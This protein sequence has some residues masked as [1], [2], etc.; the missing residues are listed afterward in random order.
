MKTVD[1]VFC[2]FPPKEKINEE[3]LCI[4][5]IWVVQPF[6]ATSLISALLKEAAL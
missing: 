4:V 2:H 6:K 5:V 3:I 1:T